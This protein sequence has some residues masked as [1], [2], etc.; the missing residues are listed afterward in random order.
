MK[1]EI[2]NQYLKNLKHDFNF[3]LTLGFFLILFFLNPINNDFLLINKFVINIIAIIII[4]K[5][6]ALLFLI[7]T[8]PL[9]KKLF[10]RLAK[11]TK[12]YQRINKLDVKNFVYYK[13]GYVFSEKFKKYIII[14]FKQNTFLLK[15][16]SSDDLSE[17]SYENFL[18][19]IS[20]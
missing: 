12:N 11:K 17:V 6:F 2:I 20:W 5:Y 19:K 10:I 1:Q 18:K 8:R 16:T 14:D 3:G 9:G 15:D 7:N 13:N 4:L